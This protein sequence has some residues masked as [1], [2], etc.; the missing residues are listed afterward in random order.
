MEAQTEIET[1]LERGK[2]ELAQGHGR[3]SA[4]AYAHG[5]QMEPNNPEVHLG[6]AEANLALGN[7]GVVQMACQ[8]VMELQP[9]AGSESLTAQALLDLL[10]HRYD[11]ALQSIDEVIKENPGIAYAHAMR[12]YLMRIMGQDYDANLARARAARL[13]Y[14]GRFENCFPPVNPAQAANY[15]ARVLNAQPPV[16]PVQPA[17][18]AQSQGERE[19]IPTW[20]RPNRMQRQM[21]RTRFALGQYPGL[22]TNILIGINVVIFLLMEITGGE[23][24]PLFQLGAQANENIAM[25]EVW[26]LLTGMFL[27]DPSNL[28]HLGFN[29]ISLFIIGRQV[30]IFYGKIRYLIIYLFSGLI[31]GLVYYFMVPG[32]VTIGASGAIFGILG[33]M[34]VFLIVNRRALGIYGGGVIRNWFVW[35]ALN[36]A[37]G[38]VPGS[39]INIIAHIGGLL[40]GMVIA[41]LL[42]PRSRRGRMMI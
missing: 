11:R 15:K 40:S 41:Y 28:L 33:A 27:H 29:M 9:S 20:S 30:E 7:Y 25:G 21:V 4:I 23:A 19:Q 2:Q 36:L 39:S 8:K 16:A 5:A 35:L 10:E 12:S 13:S 38:L 24:S 3:E 17:E 22:V 42:I 26:R 6:L 37:I 31:G 34:G 32:G 18:P 14:G 1:Y